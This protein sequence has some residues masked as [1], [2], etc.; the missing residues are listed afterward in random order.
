MIIIFYH[1]CCRCCYSGYYYTIILI[2]R[3]NNN[4][5][6][7]IDS[8]KIP[9]LSGRHYMTSLRMKLDI[10]FVYTRCE[11]FDGDKVKTVIIPIL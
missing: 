3:I 6:N 2:G 9:A 8:R 4:N 10:I 7:N 11:M 5:N 1:Y